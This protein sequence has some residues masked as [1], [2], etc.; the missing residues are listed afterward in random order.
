MMASTPK[1][2]LRKRVHLVRKFAGVGGYGETYGEPVTLAAAPWEAESA[3]KPQRED[4]ASTAEVEPR[5]R[6]GRRS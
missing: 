4:S 2:P 5:L 1:R 3:L 6:R